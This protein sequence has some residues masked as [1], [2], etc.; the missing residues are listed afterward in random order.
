METIDFH[1]KEGKHLEAKLCQLSDRD[2]G[3]NFTIS[4]LNQ[5]SKFHTKNG[6]GGGGLYG[7]AASFTRVLAA[8]L[9]GKLLKKETVSEMLTPQLKDADFFHRTV[10]EDAQS[11]MFRVGVLGSIPRE[12]KLNFGLGGLVTLED[13]KGARRS[14]SISWSGLPNCYWVCTSDL[15]YGSKYMLTPSSGPT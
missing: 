6:S 11:D 10:V 8:L 5:F 4:S 15:L 13:I 7:D 9:G 3:G 12:I 14:G 2:A 1:I